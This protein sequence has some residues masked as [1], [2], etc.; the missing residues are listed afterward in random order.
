MSRREKRQRFSQWLSEFL[1]ARP[2]RM[3]G[4]STRAILVEPLETRQV[5]AGDGFMALLGSS[6]HATYD[7]DTHSSAATQDLSGA[8]LTGEGELAAEGEPANDLVAFAKALTDSGTRFFGAAWCPFCTE[9]KELFQD[10][11]NFLPFIEV[12]NPDRTP[13]QIA[14]SEGITEYPTWEFPDGSRLTGVQTLQ[15]LAQRANLTIPQSSTPSMVALSNV[16][17]GI[18]SPLHIPIDAYDPNGNPLTITVSSSN[19]SLLTAQA[20]SGNRSLRLSMQGFGDM[21]FELFE[22]KAPRPTGRVIE[23]AQDGFYDGVPFH[24]VINNFVIQAGDR[25]N[26]NGTGGSTL[27]DFDDQFHLDLQHNRTGVLSYAKSSDDTNDSQFFITEGPQRFLDFNHSVFG[28]LVEGEAVREAISNTATNS[29]DRPVNPV[30]INA[31]TVFDD[32]ENG[33]IMLKPTGTG[34]GTATISVTVTD[35][36]GNSTSQNF[37]ATVVQD[38][39]NGAPFLNPIPTVQ[40]QAGVPTQFTLTAQDAEND[41]LIYSVTKLGTE[42]YTVTVDSATGVVTVTPQVGFTGQLQFRATVRQSSAPTTSSPDDNQIV[43][44]AVSQSSPTGIDLLPASDSGVSD[45]DNI[46][47]A[48][49]LTFAVSGT[50]VGAVVEVLS[51]GNVVGTAT[52]TGSTTQVVVSS[53]A[54]LGQGSVSFTSRQRVSGVNSSPSQSLAVILDSQA[55]A[56]I[57]AGVIPASAIID[58]P[59]AIDLNHLEEGQGLVYALAGAP[60]GMT[61]NATNGQLAWT[62]TSAQ[63]GTQSLTLKL[64]DA[65]GNV[66]DQAITI[67]VIQQPRVRISLN[68]VDLNGLP[69]TTIATGQQFKVQ[70]V[71]NDLRTGTANPNAPTGVYAAYLDL[72][73]DSNIIEPVATNPI[74]YVDPYL[75]DTS[76]VT[77]TP[78]LIDELGAFSDQ[79][80]RLGSGPRVLAEVTFLAKAAGNPLLRSESADQ[81]GNDILLYDVPSA[82]PF[83]QVEFGTSAFVVGADFTVAN[84]VFNF[85]EDEGVQSLNVLSNDTVTGG[86]VLTITTVSS[87][88]GGGT[89]TIAADGRTLNYTSAANFNGAE[90]FTYTVQ[91]QQG[92]PQSATVTVQVADVNDPPVAL[93]DTFTVF[94]GSTQNVLDVLLNDTTGVDSPSSESLVISAVSSGSAGGTIERGPSG[95]TVRYTPAA[96]FTGT[97]TFTYTLSDGRGGTATGTVSVAVNLQNPPPTPQNYAF[98]VVEDAPEASFN[99]LANDTTND[100]TETLS[101]SAVGTSQVG[102]T[103]S[104]AEDGLSVRY[105]PAANFAGTEVLTYTL[106]DSGGATAVGQMT[107]TVTPVNDPP[108]AVDDTLE[109]LSAQATTTLNVLLNDTN[110]DQGETLTITAVSQPPTGSGTLAISTNGQ[111]L[112]YTSPSSTFE[113]QFSFTYTIGDGSGL[114][115]TATVTLNVR[116]F[117]PRKISG[118]VNAGIETLNDQFYFAGFPLILTGT[119]VTGADVSVQSQVGA[120]GAF[121][122]DNL[123]PG[124]YTLVREPLA[125]LS[126]SGSSVT[127]NSGVSDGDVVSNLMVTGSLKVGLFDI[128]DFLGSTVKNSLTVA[129]NADGSTNWLAPR[130]DWAQLSTLQ[131]Q[132]DSSGNA[133]RINAARGTQSNLQATLPLNNRSITS[134]VGTESSMRL[135]RVRGSTSQAGLAAGTSS[136][137]TASTPT[138]SSTNSSTNT[139]GSLS[140]EG[141]GPESPAL[142]ALASAEAVPSNLFSPASA[143]APSGLAASATLSDQRATDDDSQGALTPPQSPSQA[144]RQLLGS[145]SRASLNAASAMQAEAVDVAMQSVLPS[146]ELK[147]SDELQDTIAHSGQLS[148]AATDAIVAQL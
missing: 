128:R 143:T 47:N 64:T 19:P 7:Q 106:R 34:T 66:L 140:G 141:E 61:I 87:P 2:P 30:L 71:V 60:A 29:A 121:A 93:N 45:S 51:G 123:A 88:T 31:A 94:R 129:L 28:Q 38:T 18:G 102:S 116:N 62:P 52:A 107:F 78:G 11:G 21:V 55:P 81:L 117:V 79:T 104:V 48:Q 120:G 36:E 110:V 86:A 132:M 118:L 101:V 122:F 124:D 73:F 65:A 39:A 42:N 135:L 138:S 142:S 97:E 96:N 125:F 53:V 16:N 56:A 83:S 119:D 9:Q 98:T 50:T 44:V 105:R 100:P 76:G 24:R 13:N 1:L 133:L 92:I 147:L 145:A 68:A 108:N 146:L 80:S 70:V 57:A 144:I 114:T 148:S 95:L 75:N 130:G 4:L 112:I 99:V 139:T 69:L 26:Q 3:D 111:N 43:T 10:G 82:T 8:A 134:V 127:I 15:T 46:T 115:D 5:M 35:T 91:N 113:G 59:L 126:D 131:A 17:V 54:S 103:V 41:T 49:S 23:L 27:G 20:I 14:T 6:Y 63:L 136:A 37:Q 72:L 74:N 85:D 33:L 77:T 89:V 25:Q 58:A 32:T 90:T 40:A 109:A 22:D 84:D 67:N 137:G 12:T